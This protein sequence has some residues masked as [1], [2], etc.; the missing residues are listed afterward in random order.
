VITNGTLQI[1]ELPARAA[2][3]VAVKVVAW[4]FGRG[5]EPLVQTAQPVEQVVQIEDPPR[6]KP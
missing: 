6:P 1:S 5:V 3:P 4:Q 2:F